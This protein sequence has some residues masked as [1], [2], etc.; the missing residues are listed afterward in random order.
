[1]N[2]NGG[3]LLRQCVESVLH[4]AHPDDELV[5]VD[6]A[7]TDGSIETIAQDFQGVR[8]VRNKT[9]LG[10]GGGNNLGAQHAQGDYLAFLN[11]DTTVEPGWLDPLIA[12]LD[13]TPQAGLA[14]PR[15]L[16]MDAPDT[17]NTCGN[18]MHYTGLTLC[19]GMGFPADTYQTSDEVSAVSGAAFVVRKTLFH[20]LGGFDESFFLYMEDTDLSLRTRIAGYQCL[21]VPT[22]V[23]YH[24]YRL[25][26][27]PRKTYYQEHGRYR[28]LLKS[29]QW[30]TL[31]WLAPALL[32]AEIVTWG[33]VL[34]R[35]NLR[36]MN[37]LRAYASVM[38]NLRTIMQQR[39][40]VQS[41]R[42]VQ[43][44]DIILGC[45][46]HIS[47]EQTGTGL[48]SILAS[49]L[50]NPWF[51]MWKESLHRTLKPRPSTPRA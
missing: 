41:L 35:D 13:A 42:R 33:F 32:L 11:P 30:R 24:S 26:F 40:H 23:V 29:L 7:S 16:L 17:I 25:R 18:N 37:K 5:V 14:T 51:T 44:Y 21:Y 31:L 50:F 6:N 2:Y 28:L 12:S 15:I 45:S 9:N 43:D 10:F 4:A 48:A 19:R 49:R 20:T 27:G 46:A 34:T 47:F 39:Q 8:I 22:S 1:V 3:N 36:I 38:R